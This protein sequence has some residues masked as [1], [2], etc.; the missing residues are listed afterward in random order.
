MRMRTA[1]YE[2]NSESTPEKNKMNDLKS[3][4]KSLVQ[5]D[6]VSEATRISVPTPELMMRAM[7]TSPR[8][9]FLSALASSAIAISSNFCGVT[10]YILAGLPENTVEK[11]GL[12]IF[13]PRGEMKRFKSGEFQYT[14]VVPKEWVQDTAVELAKIQNRAARLDYSMRKNNNGS[15]PDVAYGPPGYFNDKGI[16][17]SDTN[18]STLVSKVRPG[19]TLQS[20]GSPTQAAETLLRISLAPE[21]SGKIGTL[22]AACEEVR[23]ES[24][25]YQFEYKVDRGDKGLPLRAI[26]IIAVRDGDVLVTMTVVALEREW[27]DE[28]FEGKLRKIAQ[29]FKL[30]K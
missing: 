18:V 29:S 26:S 11:T 15:V 22:L 23:G 2:T 8:R 16:S 4:Q 12:D 5:S 25:L 24:N 30:T 20:L 10:S 6:T 9:I 13:Y 19:F 7:N 14:F 1:S 28:V 21:G 3:S 27:Q 17:Q